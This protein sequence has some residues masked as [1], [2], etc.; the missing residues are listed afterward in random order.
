VNDRDQDI[1]IRVRNLSKRFEIYQRPADM[2]WETITRKPCHIEYWALRDISFEVRRGEVLGIIGR[3]GAGKSTLLKILTG[4]LE[5]TEGEVAIN[6]S[7]SALL[8]LGTGFNPEYSG[9]ENIEMSGLCLGMSRQE[10]NERVDWIIDFSELRAVIDQPF[11]TYSTGMQARLMFSTAVSVDPE[12]LMVDE[13]LAVGDA[14]FQR[15][16]IQKFYEIRDSGCTILF[17]SHNRYQ[18]NTICE[19]ALYLDQGRQLMFGP[20]GRVLNRYMIDSEEASARSH[21]KRAAT[22][23]HEKTNPTRPILVRVSEAASP[24][25]EPQEYFRILRVCLF[26]ADGMPVNEI[27]SGQDI[28]LQLEFEAVTEHVPSMISFVFNLYRHDD[29][30]ICGT[31]TLMD[32]LG[33]QRSGRRGVVSIDFPRL[34]LLAGRYKWRVAVNDERGFIVHAEAKEVCPFEVIDGFKAIGMIN[35][36]RRWHFEISD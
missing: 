1:V 30:Y 31:T 6:G 19:R 4:T 23:K 8:E 10:I 15:R 7:I 17:V 2:L 21:A 16:C 12:I 28:R 20:T 36:D 9:R 5:K 29:L 3:N 14:A 34:P 13:I 11:R 24:A 26:G 22:A 33:P 27:K 18:V 32:G 25:A 35:L